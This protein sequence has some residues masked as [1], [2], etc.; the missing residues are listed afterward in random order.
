MEH[1]GFEPL[2]STMRML[3]APNCA[4]TP[5]RNYSTNFKK[6]KDFCQIFCIFSYM[7]LLF[8]GTPANSNPTAHLEPLSAVGQTSC[9]SLR[10]SSEPITPLIGSELNCNPCVTFSVDFHNIH[11]QLFTIYI[12]LHKNQPLYL[13]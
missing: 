13:S 3:R 4:N 11:L 8:T 1:R 5:Y 6:R 2:A 7:R 10:Y 9:Q 12:K